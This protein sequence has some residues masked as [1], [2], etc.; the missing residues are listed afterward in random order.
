MELH[1]LGVDGGYTQHDVTE[2]ARVFTGWTI[3]PI[4]DVAYGSAM[5]GLVAKIGEKNLAQQGFVH[6]GD[7][8]F[9]P[10][11]H[12]KGEK[13]VLGRHFA[14]NGGYHERIEVLQNLASEHAT[15][16]CV[17]SKLAAVCLR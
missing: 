1:S 15:A 6:E 13:V 8:L 7:F 17:T 2:A 10:N 5:K 4:S 16:R 14:A 11:R 3:Y 9:T 12:D